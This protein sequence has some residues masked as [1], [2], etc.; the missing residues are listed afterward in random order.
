MVSFNN[1]CYSKKTFG[2]RSDTSVDTIKIEIEAF[3][4][5]RQK[6]WVLTF[7]FPYEKQDKIHSKR[8]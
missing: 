4:F 2:D 8:K 1:S 7:L 5:L 6:T 3:F